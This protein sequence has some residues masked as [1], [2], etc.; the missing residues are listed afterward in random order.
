M[1][2]G[3]VVGSTKI[4]NFG[5]QSFEH[6]STKLWSKTISNRCSANYRGARGALR[7]DVVP[8]ARRARAPVAS[9][10]E[11]HAFPRLTLRP[12]VPRFYPAPRVAPRHP[13][14]TPHAA[15]RADRRS[16]PR[17]AVHARLTRL[18]RTT[19]E[20]T[21]SPCRHHRTC[22]LFKA[23]VPSPPSRH[24]RRSRPSHRTRHGRRLASR[25]LAR[26]LGHRASE[27]LP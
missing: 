7:R 13:R 11:P 20:S 10:S 24:H 4:Y 9:V 2:F 14:R 17:S 18:R 8:A 16:I 21:S 6:F 3:K 1:A 12:E 5:I 15:H 25:R 19:T 23:T 27:H 22:A 26:P